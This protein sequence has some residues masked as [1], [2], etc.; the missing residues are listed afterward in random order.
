[1]TTKFYLCSVCGNVI[2][3]LVDSGVNVVC[4]GKPMKQLIPSTDDTAVEKHLPVV[5]FL[6]DGKIKVRVGERP[7]PMIMEHHISFIYLETD[8]GGHI[9]YLSEGQAP[10]AEFFLKEEKAIAV[11]EYC[12]IHGLWKKDLSD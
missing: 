9:Q 5:E 1:M 10:E 3:K 12:N 7:H 8:K 6:E 11:Y 2:I 4:C